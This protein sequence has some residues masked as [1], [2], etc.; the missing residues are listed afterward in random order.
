[1]HASSSGSA[2]A[3][4]AILLTVAGLAA[5]GA[6]LAAAA[7]PLDG[8]GKIAFVRND[9]IYTINP[10]G[11]G[12]TALTTSGGNAGPAWSPD[13]TEI[14]YVH[15]GDDH[16]S[17]LWIMDADGGGKTRLTSTGGVRRT[18]PS[19][20]PDGTKLSYGG[21]CDPEI[22]DYSGHYLSV[23]DRTGGSGVGELQLTDDES[24]CWPD[25]GVLRIEGRSSWSPSGDSV[26]YYA[27]YGCGGN[28][29]FIVE[30]VFADRAVHF[31]EYIGGGGTWGT[32]GNPAISPDG[33]IVAYDRD[34]EDA[35]GASH[36]GIALRMR[37][38]SGLL[39]FRE[40]EKDRQLAFAPSQTRVALVRVPSHRILLASM[41]GRQREFL[42]RGSQPSWQPV[43]APTA[44]TPAEVRPGELVDPIG[45]ARLLI[46]PASPSL[47]PE[48]P[49]GGS[50]SA[51]ISGNG[52]FVTFTSAANDLVPY[53]TH[54]LRNVFLYD[55]ADKL[56]YVVSHGRRGQPTE[57][58]LGSSGSAIGASSRFVVF[59]SDG[60]NIAPRDEDIWQDV[61]FYRITK[62]G[63]RAAG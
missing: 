17:D 43:A 31:I 27:D 50:S 46:E 26:V 21:P 3:G 44:G 19:W 39:D 16:V 48:S 11:S 10:D 2:R 4:L 63:L 55:A 22:C 34:Y 8:D 38:G 61:F 29:E 53:E 59:A 7:P 15:T 57:G 9:D 1:M 58:P 33:G 41:H 14:A 32:L 12:M 6:P 51:K 40:A 60:S 18:A 28:D 52:R 23:I 13:G 24:S 56:V 37:D 20:S 49:E 36:V 30:Y 35:G 5:H 45:R 54:Y 42:T 47:H 62:V 25:T